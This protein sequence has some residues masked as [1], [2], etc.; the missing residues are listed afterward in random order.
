MNKIVVT[1]GAGFLGSRLISTLLAAQGTENYPAF[2]QIISVDLAECPIKDPRVISMTGDIAN[3][4]FARQVITK[5]T[6]AVYHMAAVLSGQSEAE[7]DVGMRVNV[8]GTRALL[9]AARHTEDKPIFV[10]TSSLAVFGGVMPDTVPEDLALLPQSSYG[11]EKAI[12]EILVG[13]YSRRGF[14]DGRVC[15]LPT[16]VVRPGKPNSAASSFASGIIREPLSG[17]A[18]NNPVPPA[19]RMWLSSPNTVVKNLAHALTVS[20]QKLGINRVLNLPGLCVS[21]AQMLDSL[22]KV[23]GKDVRALVSEVPEQR[24]IDIVCSWPGDFDV[25]RPLS[26]GFTSDADFDSIVCQYRDEFVTKS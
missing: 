23:A 20:A 11:A 3:G 6:V 25:S 19:T 22:E 2:D 8:D 16:I 1:G 5:G 15:R 14:V 24:V 12:G 9:E 26:L 18:S 17:I 4:E 13:D 10:F 21:V 7:F